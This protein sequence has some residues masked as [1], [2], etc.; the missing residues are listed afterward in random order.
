MEI[1]WKSDQYSRQVGHGVH[2]L[3]QNKYIKNISTSGTIHTE[4]L[5]NAG[6]RLQTSKTA[7]KPPCIQVGKKEKDKKKKKKRKNWLTESEL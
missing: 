3:L 1:I 2:P 7:R 5:L 6:R 4:H